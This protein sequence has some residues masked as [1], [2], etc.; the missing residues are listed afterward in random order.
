MWQQWIMKD[1]NNRRGRTMWVAE[2]AARFHWGQV[3]KD[4]TSGYSESMRDML[5][6]TPQGARGS[7]KGWGPAF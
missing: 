1:P 2:T 7:V 6:E 3:L 4:R 5:G